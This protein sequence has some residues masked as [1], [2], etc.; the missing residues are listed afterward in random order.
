MWRL[1]GFGLR[2]GIVFGAALLAC[3]PGLPAQA[4][5]PPHYPIGNALQGYAQDVVNP[6][7]SPPG[8]NVAGCAPS[9]AHPYPVILLPGTLF[10]LADSF[11]ALGPALADAGYCVFGLNYGVTELTTA[12]GG[13]SWSDGPIPQSAS[14]LATFVQ[15]VL[16]QTR[17]AQVDIVG[18]SQGGMMPR[19]YMRFDGGQRY[20]HELVGLAPSNHGTTLDGL[21]ALI[22]A[23]M[24]L[25][26]AGP[27]TLIG[28]PA[29]TEQQAGSPT[30]QAL[31]AG[32]DTL[33]GVRYVVIE[34]ADDE[35]V[36]PYT[37]AFLEGLNVQNITLQDQCHLDL[38]DHLGIPYDPVAIQDV[39]NA[40]GPD[41]P[42]FNPTCSL[43][44]PGV[45]G[46]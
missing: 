14:Q 36:T 4:G 5:S 43:S 32:G 12:S 13:R 42:S 41:S 23:D 3:L 28:C 27:F 31:N 8:V 46:L 7:S 17:A 18:W 22:D 16:Q 40:L 44:L 39:M 29:C 25:G 10:D 30:L 35:V 20:V 33:P 38:S 45:G 2:A 37:S 34:T 9:A 15:S 11:Q 26:L 1:S 6:T 21:F 19:W 24:A